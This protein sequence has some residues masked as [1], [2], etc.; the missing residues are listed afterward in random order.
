MSP[1]PTRAIDERTSLRHRAVHDLLQQGVGLLECSRRLGWGLNTVKRYA[2]AA[3]AQELQRPPQYRTTLV[4]PYRTHLR[5]R[6][7]AEPGVSVTRLLGEIRELGYPG[8][9]NLLVRYLNQG[10]L[11]LDRAVPSPRRL[12]SWIMTRPSDLA[13]AH[14]LHLN[15]L[16]A[17]C[18]HLSV[19]AELVRRF[20]DL[21]TGRRSKDLPEWMVAAESSELPGMNSFVHG[22]R[23]DLPAVTAGLS[24][25][26]SNGPMEGT[27]TKVTPQT[28]NVRPSRIP[29]P[30]PT[31]PPRPIQQDHW[32]TVIA[33]EPF[34]LQSRERAMAILRTGMTVLDR[35][36]GGL[37]I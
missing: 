25:P 20:A 31:D 9:A 14:R 1:A 12:T 23:K 16:L 36:Q 2:R 5:A 27:N 3:T 37:W 21:L 30:V 13:E 17:S 19:L 24:L 15:D 32:T 18:P 29:T 8:S 35:A 22:L 34:F 6:L 26:Y 7:S 33:P 11:D 4:D 28:T 10:R